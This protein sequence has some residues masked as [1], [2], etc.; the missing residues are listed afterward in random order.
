MLYVIKHPDP[1][2]LASCFPGE[3]TPPP[4]AEEMTQEAFESWRDAELAAGWE[5]EP[6][7]VA[8]A[9]D[10]ISAGVTKLTIMRRLSALGKW[11]TFKA[12]LASLPEEVQDA[13]SLAQEIRPDDPLFLANAAALKALLGLSD[14]QFTALLMP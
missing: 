8:V 3:G 7:P 14:D 5:P 6:M 4:G 10:T 11:T 9:V 13:W 1:F 12:L 2:T